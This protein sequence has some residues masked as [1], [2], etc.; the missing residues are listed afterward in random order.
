[1]HAQVMQYLTNGIPE[2]PARFIAALQ[3]FYQTPPL[4]AQ[5]FPWPEDLC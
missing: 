5:Q 4:A 1:M 3:D 2:R